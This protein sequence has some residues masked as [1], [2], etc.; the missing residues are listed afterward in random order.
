M[1]TNQVTIGEIFKK[2]PLQIVGCV[3]RRNV[4]KEAAVFVSSKITFASANINLYSTNSFVFNMTEH[5]LQ[6]KKKSLL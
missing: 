5:D 3:Y 4:Q 6:K 2:W 1:T